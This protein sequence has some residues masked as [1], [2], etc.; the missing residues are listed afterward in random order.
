MKR[1]QTW[2][3]PFDGFDWLGHFDGKSDLDIIADV[4]QA[5]VDLKGHAVSP[6]GKTFVDLCARN[7]EAIKLARSEKIRAGLEKKKGTENAAPP[8]KA[9][10]ASGSSGKSST[11][12]P[13]ASV[14]EAEEGAMDSALCTSGAPVTISRK[15]ARIEFEAFRKAFPGT[16]RGAAV[17]W[18]N[19]SKKNFPEDAPLLMPALMREMAHREECA[20]VGAFVP[21]WANL[22]TWI[23]QRRWTQELPRPRAQQIRKT[24]EDMENDKKA[25]MLRWLKDRE[26]GIPTGDNYDEIPE[27]ENTEDGN[28]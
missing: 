18:E 24:S 26:A 7:V 10:S 13:E 17:E 3:Y 11:V 8:G 21:E 2:M 1:G 20:R 5:C 28:A 14:R 16:R 12:T 25:R 27:V 22:S 4:R 9:E 15:D 19:F 23:N 6:S